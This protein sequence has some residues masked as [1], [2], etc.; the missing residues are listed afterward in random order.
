VSALRRW[1]RTVDAI[2]DLAPVLEWYELTMR[3]PTEDANERYFR[4]MRAGRWRERWRG[5]TTG[6]LPRTLD[7]RRRK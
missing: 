1:N 5:H 3:G 6:A 2:G 7:P 4:A